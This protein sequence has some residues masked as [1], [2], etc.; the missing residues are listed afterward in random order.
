[1]IQFVASVVACS[2]F[3]LVAVCGSLAVVGGFWHV[4]VFSWYANSPV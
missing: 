4:L 3:Q 1:M 2:C